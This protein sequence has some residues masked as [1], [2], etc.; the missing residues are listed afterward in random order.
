[1]SIVS[2]FVAE[3]RIRDWLSSRSRPSCCYLL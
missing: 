1:M 2:L 3:E